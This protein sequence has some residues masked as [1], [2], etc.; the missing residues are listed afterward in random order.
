MA[1]TAS[2]VLEH[3]VVWAFYQALSIAFDWLTR[4][5][6]IIHHELLGS[7]EQAFGELLVKIRLCRP[8]F[9]AKQS[10]VQPM[11]PQ[12]ASHNSAGVMMSSCQHLISAS[13][14]FCAGYLCRRRWL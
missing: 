12:A 4:K 1:S 2:A 3:V 8:P 14:I 9:V 11:Q 6:W 5:L 7:G 13:C 10:R